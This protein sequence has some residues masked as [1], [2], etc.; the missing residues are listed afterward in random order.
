MEEFLL[1]LT[2]ADH[3]V[4]ISPGHQGWN[5]IEARKRGRLV[6]RVF[7]KNGVIQVDNYVP[8]SKDADYGEEL[9]LGQKGVW[10]CALPSSG[11]MP[12]ALLRCVADAVAHAGGK[13]VGFVRPGTPEQRSQQRREW[14]R[15]RLRS[16]VRFA[17]GGAAVGEREA[18][19]AAQLQSLKVS[20]HS[21]PTPSIVVI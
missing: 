19:A 9:K 10:R 13:R 12:D 3:D 1:G 6:A 16:S 21:Q 11:E 15:S 5:A 8:G 7:P 20:A 17:V 18:L 2:A 14:A 4:T